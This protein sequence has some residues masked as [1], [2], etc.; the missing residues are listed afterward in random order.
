MQTKLV[1]KQPA[2]L[3][4]RFQ[5]GA[6]GP[7]GTITVGDVTT[8]APGSDA[9]VTNVGTP[10]NAILDFTI[11][12][13]LTGPPND[14]EIGT[15]DTLPYGTPA[16][17][18]ITGTA[19]N[20]TLNLGLPMG[21]QGPSGS[22]TDGDKGDISVSS[23]GSV[24]TID[25]SAV[26]E[27][28]LADD[29]VTEAKIGDA[30]LKAIAGLTSA[31]DKLPYFIGAGAAD[32]T[33]LT[34][35][36]RSMI[37]ASTPAGGRAVIGATGP[38]QSG[39]RNLIIN[40]DFR[41]NERA[42]AGGALSAGVYGHDRWK[43]DTGGANYSVSGGVATIS[44]GTIVQPIEGASIATGTHVISW[45]GT[46][47]CTVDGVAKTSGQ[48]FSLTAGTNCIVKFT[49]GTVS[50][51]QVEPGDVPTAFEMRPI[52]LEKMLCERFYQRFGNS[53]YSTI[54][55]HGFASTTLVVVGAIPLR[56]PMAQ[57]PTTIATSFVATV[58]AQTATGIAATTG[59]AVTA[60]TSDY[61]TFGITVTTS[62]SYTVGEA[63]IIRVANGHWIAFETEL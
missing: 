9:E 59:I 10:E 31:A 35:Q 5:P 22:V 34:S 23:A 36:G 21:E 24:W 58:T 48:S 52:D 62:G 56:R 7:A 55:G 50:K 14:L 30:E 2:T 1:L 20:Q 41:V 15:V 11:P 25:N 39:F 8:G 54:V 3:R 18:T 40:G 4:L 33:D 51:V 63:A 49:G 13:G 38:E 60:S 26:S 28:K 19:P 29:A 43:A 17:A 6:T 46:A 57:I 27:S 42:F 44:S 12:S 37:A 47:T 53:L 16:T 61:S 45:Q 32:L